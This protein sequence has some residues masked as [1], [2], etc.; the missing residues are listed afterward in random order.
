MSNVPVIKGDN[1]VL[2]GADGVYSG[3]GIVTSGN[4]KL[5][6]EKLEVADENGYT[7]AVIYFNEKNQCSFEMIVKTAAPALA[8]G[9]EITL[10]G[11]A[12]CLVDD[13]ELMFANKDVQKFRVNATK[14]AAIAGS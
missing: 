5:D 4:N 13:T 9:D 12:A 7:V 3:N 1:T 2:F 11:V 6:G 10:C 14:Y 8:R